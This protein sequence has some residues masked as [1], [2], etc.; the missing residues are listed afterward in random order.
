M[1][2]A[3]FPYRKLINMLFWIGFIIALSIGLI[4]TGLVREYCRHFFPNF[5]DRLFDVIFL[6]LLFLGLGLTAISHNSNRNEII[7]LERDLDILKY[8]EVSLWGMT[9]HSSKA[10][11]IV[12]QLISVRTPIDN[13]NKEYIIHYND[14]DGNNKSRFNCKPGAKEACYRVIEKIPEYPFSYQFLA[15][16]L[17]E[18]NDSSWVQ[19]AKQAKEI[20]GKTTKIPGHHSSHDTALTNIN[21]MLKLE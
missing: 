15:Q 13:W 2:I 5:D 6:L 9:G 20:F 11:L 12:N 18:E 1:L 21:E 4:G 8:Q 7:T 16:C 14:D 19:V 3:V 10:G 17:K